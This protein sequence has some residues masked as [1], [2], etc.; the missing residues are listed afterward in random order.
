MDQRSAGEVRVEVLRPA[1]GLDGRPGE[2]VVVQVV[3]EDR[4]FLLST[5]VDEIERGGLRVVRALHPIVGVRR[6]AE[7]RVTAILPARTAARRESV[8][9]LEVEGH[10]PTNEEPALADRLRRLISDIVAAT[11]D[12]DAM[13]ARIRAAADA[14]RAGTW[15]AYAGSDPAADEQEVAALLDWLLED[16]LVLLGVREYVRVDL[17]GAPCIEVVEGSGLGLLGDDRRSRF[18]SPVAIADLP[19]RVRAQIEVRRC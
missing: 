11:D 10:L 19:P 17:D 7:G 16:N 13:R 3:T 18:A 14:L 8:I 9:H 1:T 12:H 4:P 5:V 15:T 6:D 2:N